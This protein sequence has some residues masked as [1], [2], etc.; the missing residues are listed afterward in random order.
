MDAVT[1]RRTVLR[2]GLAALGGSALLGA[3][4]SGGSPGAGKP[5]ATTAAPASGSPTTS[6]APS[7]DTLASRLHGQLVRPGDTDYDRARA[8]F[9]PAFDGVRPQGVVYAADPGDVAE[10]IRFAGATGVPLAARCGGH[11]YAGYSTSA[12]LVLDV[13][14]MNQVSVGGDGLAT[15]GAG[16]RLIKLYTDLATAGRALPGGS[17]PTVGI[18]GLTLGGGIGVLGRL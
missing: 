5:A 16:T 6:P 12:G 4:S 17:C 18:S 9:D 13:T 2:A 14:R 10:A 3:C 7:W 11:S 8:L 15:V 1:D